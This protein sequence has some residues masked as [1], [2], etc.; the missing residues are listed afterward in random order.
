M[1]RFSVE[2]ALAIVYGRRI[3]ELARNS[4]LQ[5]GIIALVVISML[6]SAWSIYSW[7]KRTHS[8]SPA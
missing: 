8:H 1:V 7:V 5:Q 3:L 6:G 2:G 4:V